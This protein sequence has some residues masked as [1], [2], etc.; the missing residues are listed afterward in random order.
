MCCWL[1]VN[2]SDNKFPEIH[3]RKLPVLPALA[4]D[5]KDST[6]VFR[7]VPTD[8]MF[9][10]PLGDNGAELERLE[11]GKLIEEKSSYIVDFSGFC[12]IF[13]PT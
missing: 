5:R 12:T 13:A 10:V 11:N 6:Y 8:D 1:G 3:C 9:Y 7:F 4:Q 2:F